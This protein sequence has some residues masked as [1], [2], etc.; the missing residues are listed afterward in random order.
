M[1]TDNWPHSQARS[2]SVVLLS[3][4]LGE[5][6]VRL[7]LLKPSGSVRP[8]CEASVVPMTASV[9]QPV[10]AQ[11][12]LEGNFGQQKNKKVCILYIE[13]KQIS[14]KTEQHFTHTHTHARTHTRTSAGCLSSRHLADG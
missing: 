6:I 3:C 8:V 1:S 2:V 9:P 4:L 12:A 7:H 10:G 14:G 13:Y 5:L 11:S